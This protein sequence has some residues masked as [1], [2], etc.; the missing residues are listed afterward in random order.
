MVYLAR[1][2]K[3]DQVISM[4]GRSL[5]LLIC[6]LS[7]RSLGRMSSS[8]FRQ[9]FTLMGIDSL[10]LVTTAS[11]LVSIPLCTHAVLELQK[12]GAQAASGALIAVGLLRELGSLTV[13]MMWAARCAAFLSDDTASLIRS[14]KNLDAE[15]FAVRYMA[16]LAAGIP[17]SAYGMVVGFVAAALYAPLIGVSSMSDFL[18]AARQAVNT[19]DVSVYF[20]KLAFLNPTVVVLVSMTVAAEYRGSPEMSAT[21]AV[22]GTTI[23]VLIANLLFTL[24]VY[25]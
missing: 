6:S 4:F 24:A 20:F 8:E 18:E 5:R 9:Y 23:G 13:S 25:L 19:R 17:L 10:S 11:I 12:F 14:G 7:P 3:A 2:T 1:I 22:S 15:F 16:A 21:T